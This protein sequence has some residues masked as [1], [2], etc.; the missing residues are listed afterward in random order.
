[1]LAIPLPSSPPRGTLLLLALPCWRRMHSAAAWLAARSCRAKP[2]SAQHCHRTKCALSSAASLLMDTPSAHAQWLVAYCIL[3]RIYIFETIL[4]MPI[5]VNLN[6]QCRWHLQMG[7]GRASAKARRASLTKLL[8]QRGAR[9]SGRWRNCLTLCHA[10]RSSCCILR[11]FLK[12][13][14]TGRTSFQRK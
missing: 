10:R 9:N 1:M 12:T 11:W 4:A 6:L 13:L 7:S 2:A 8:C 3:S 5:A 14:I